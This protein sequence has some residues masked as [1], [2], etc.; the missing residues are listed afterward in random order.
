MHVGRCER[1]SEIA[2]VLMKEHKSNNPKTEDAMLIRAF[3]IDD[4]DLEP[5]ED[6]IDYFLTHD[7]TVAMEGGIVASSSVEAGVL[8]HIAVQESYADF[9]A[10]NRKNSENSLPAAAQKE[11]D[12]KRQEL[13]DRLAA[14]HANSE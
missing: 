3:K 12:R 6:E 7:Y 5:T 10:M 11:V 2:H 8:G 4:I 9:V 13:L 14:R 1:S